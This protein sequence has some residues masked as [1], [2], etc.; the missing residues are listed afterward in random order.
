MINVLFLFI[1]NEYHNILFSIFDF[2]HVKFMLI[3]DGLKG[4]KLSSFTKILSFSEEL[5]Y[6]ISTQL[7]KKSY[8]T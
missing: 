5:N 1:K 4:F 8:Y 3:P 2:I 6:G 7:Q